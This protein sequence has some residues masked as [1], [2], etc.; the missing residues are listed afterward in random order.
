MTEADDIVLS[1][2]NWSL[3]RDTPAG[4]VTV[5]SDIELTLRRGEWLGVLGENGSGKTTFVKL[6]CRLYDPN[7]GNITLDGID[8]RRFETAALRNQISVIFPD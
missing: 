2:Y 4:P 7:Q 6:L 1:L 3:V 8:L 5:L